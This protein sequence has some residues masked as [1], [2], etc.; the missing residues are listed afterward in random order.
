[1]C[2]DLDDHLNLGALCEHCDASRAICVSITTYPKV[3]QVDQAD[4]SPYVAGA[5]KI[6]YLF[7]TQATFDLFW[8]TVKNKTENQAEL[9]EFD[10]FENFLAA[11]QR[12]DHD[13]LTLGGLRS[14]LDKFILLAHGFRQNDSHVRGSSF[15]LDLKQAAYAGVGLGLDSDDIKLIDLLP[16]LFGAL[17]D[18]EIIR[19]EKNKLTSGANTE[20]DGEPD[21]EN[22]EK[23]KARLTEIEARCTRVISAYMFL[24]RGVVE[25]N[26]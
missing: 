23:T 24:L 11:F 7:E 17:N 15:T 21:F 13:D 5:T 10:T 25:T 26:L 1:M 12:D 6:H 4:Y 19:R 2:K 9:K 18:R 22:L 14:F 3:D 20:T 8:T 16:K